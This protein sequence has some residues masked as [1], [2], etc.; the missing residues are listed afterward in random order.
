MGGG[1]GGREREAVAG[2]VGG[3][4]E[5]GAGGGLHVAMQSRCLSAQ[6]H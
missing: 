3:L 5:T 2:G 1:G 6:W 4:G